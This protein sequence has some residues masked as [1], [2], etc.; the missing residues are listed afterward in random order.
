VCGCVDMRFE[1]SAL[2]NCI[3]SYQ[4]NLQF[5][6]SV[7][8]CRLAMHAILLLLIFVSRYHSLPILYI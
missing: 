1:V 7:V 2:D 4:S 3:H 6:I 8:I 5:S